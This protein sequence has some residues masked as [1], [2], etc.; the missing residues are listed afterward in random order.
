MKAADADFPARA[1]EKAGYR[2]VWRGERTW[3]GVAILSRNGEPIVTR[4]ALPGDPKDR[5]S[6]YLE[7]AVDGV[8]VGCL[9]LPNG[10]PRPG[11]KFDYKLAWFNRLA[12]HA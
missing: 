4:N 7:A 10:N 11:P 9:Y 1:I 12:A 6:R 8:L 5:Q 2:A 3:N